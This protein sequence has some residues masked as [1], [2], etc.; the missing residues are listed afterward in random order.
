MYVWLLCEVAGLTPTLDPRIEASVGL[1]IYN[2]YPKWFNGELS[3]YTVSF[4]G[5]AVFHFQSAANLMAMLAHCNGESLI[6]DCGIHET[7]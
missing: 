1:S 6:N 2:M 3:D 7:A 4:L 5:E